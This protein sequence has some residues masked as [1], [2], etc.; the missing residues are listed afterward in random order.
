M[1]WKKKN[2]A[3]ACTYDPA[4][5][6]PVLRASICTGEL[7]AGFKDLQTGKFSEVMLIRTEADLDEFMKLYGLTETPERIY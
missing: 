4:E 3:P 5:K 6:K 7:T 2:H 1:L